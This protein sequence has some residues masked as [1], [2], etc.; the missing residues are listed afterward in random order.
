MK[1]ILILIVVAVA[2]Y[3]GLVYKGLLSD[4]YVPEVIKSN[5]PQLNQEEET[6]NRP[7]EEQMHALA[8]ELLSPLSEGSTSIALDI[9]SLA[10]ELKASSGDLSPEAINA[11]LQFCKNLES[12]N[13]R[14]TQF[15]KELNNIKSRNEIKSNM[16]SR[17]SEA[18][19]AALKE[20]LVGAK[21]YDWNHV[22]EGITPQLKKQLATFI[23]LV[24]K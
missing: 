6:E 14:K 21:V 20:K 8:K 18:K 19:G 23:E 4:Q 11:G 15:L 1:N 24:D 17:D 3:L 22:V 13:N 5:V 12:V 10:S 7:V 2:L 9:T 16:K